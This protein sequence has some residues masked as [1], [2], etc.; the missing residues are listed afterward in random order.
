MRQIIALPIVSVLIFTQSLWI[1]FAEVHNL[2]EAKV[3][4]NNINIR[5]DAT[6]SSEI[7]CNVN[8][9]ERLEVILELYDW[10]KIKLPRNAPSFIK[11]N[12][13][14]IIDEKNA[15]V[16]KDNVNIRLKANESSSIVGKVKKD[17]VVNVL[18]DR[19]EWLKIEPVLNSFGWIH[20]KFV[21]KVIV[22]SKDE[23]DKT[24]GSSLPSQENI[25]IIA[26]TIKPK[27]IRRIATHKL[28]TE[29]NKLFL[30]KGDEEEL[31]SFNHRKAKVTGKLIT[32]GKQKYSIAEIDKIEALD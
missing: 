25:I 15:R 20:K 27:V 11:K 6:V 4:S 17:E 32:S 14:S 19:G 18:Y 28:L 29:D 3:N 5:S 21:D 24:S 26:G 12:L 30:L 13:V 7:I 1:C 16:I 31:N 10:Y 8:R 23:G 2:F 22:L 9:N